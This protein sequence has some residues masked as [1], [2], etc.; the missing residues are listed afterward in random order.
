MNNENHGV[1]KRQKR[2]IHSSYMNHILQLQTIKSGKTRAFIYKKRVDKLI[3]VQDIKP[4]QF[5]NS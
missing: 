1:Y 3:L 4:Y 5:A 2:A